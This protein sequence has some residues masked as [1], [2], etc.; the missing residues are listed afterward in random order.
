MKLHYPFLFSGLGLAVFLAIAAGNPG[1]DLPDNP[2]ELGELLFKDPILSG[3]STVSCASCHKPE[4]AFADNTAKSMGISM[5]H[6]FR[7]TP[8]IVYMTKRTQF[9]WD[10]RAPSLEAQ[11]AGP[12]SNPDEMGS[13]VA[14]AVSRLQKSDFYRRA[15]SAVYDEAPDS[16]L[17]LQAISDFERSL[18]AYDSPYD[19]FLAGD[20]KAMSESAIRGMILF[21]RGSTCGIDACHSGPDFSQDSIV[22]IGVDNPEDLGL[23]RLTHS[24]ADMGKFKTPSLRN[25]AVTG[26]YM[27]DGSVKTLREVVEFYNDFEKLRKSTAHERVKFPRPSPLTDAEIDDIVEFLKALTDNKYL[28]QI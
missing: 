20:D 6:T 23:F 9:F 27:H 21:Y 18:E 1:P 24:K 11:A 4:F 5:A 10:G 26:P 17:M 22:S 8:S 25:V 14:L 15:F 2:V 19:R 13:S 16:V 7:N 3:D 28:S 12:I